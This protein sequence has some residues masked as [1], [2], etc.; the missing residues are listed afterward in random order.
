MKKSNTA[1]ILS[2]V[3]FP[4][5]GHI[6]LKKYRTGLLLVGIS[7]GALIYIMSDIMDRAFNVVE[8]IQNGSVPPD[9]TTITAMIEQQPGGEWVGMATF[10]IVVCWLIG[11]IDCYRQSKLETNN[12]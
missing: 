11:V 10:A 7:L 8:Q 6:F 1:I 9:T 2:A 4:G 5:A 3:V 12:K